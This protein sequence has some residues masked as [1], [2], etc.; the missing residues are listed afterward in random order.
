MAETLP[1]ATTRL[2]EAKLA[3]HKLLTGASEASVGYGERSITYRTTDI[4]QLKEYI[5]Q[6][7]IETGEKSPRAPHGVVFG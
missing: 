7:E 3:L 5:R 1:D 2:L 4:A 6:L